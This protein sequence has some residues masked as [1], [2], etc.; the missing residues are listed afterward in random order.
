MMTRRRG[1]IGNERLQVASKSGGKCDALAHASRQ[2]EWHAAS[3]ILVDYA[4][5]C[6]SSFHLLRSCGP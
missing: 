6:A 3:Y 4:D 2:L 5:F 1:L